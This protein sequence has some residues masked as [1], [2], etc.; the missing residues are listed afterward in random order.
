MPLNDDI[1]AA[2]DPGEIGDLV[3]VRERFNEAKWAGYNL[4][5]VAASTVAFGCLAWA[6]VSDAPAVL[7]FISSPQ[8]LGVEKNAR[9]V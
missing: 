9:F 8:G 1:K 4:W 6:L 5:R 2:G 3:V 7:V